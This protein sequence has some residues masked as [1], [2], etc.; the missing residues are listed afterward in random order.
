MYLQKVVWLFFLCCLSAENIF[1]GNPEEWNPEE[2]E[3]LS[4]QCAV[5]ENALKRIKSS[6]SEMQNVTQNLKNAYDN[7]K[8]KLEHLSNQ[9]EL[10]ADQCMLLLENSKP[11][12]KNSKPYF[13]DSDPPFFDLD[14]TLKGVTCLW[15]PMGELEE[16]LRILQNQE[17]SLTGEKILAFSPALQYEVENLSREEQAFAVTLER[18][19]KA[20]QSSISEKKRG[21]GIMIKGRYR[22]YKGNHYEVVDV[23]R[24]SETLEKLVLYRPLYGDGGL[25]VGPFDMFFETIEIEGQPQKRFTYVGE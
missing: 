1:A 17:A 5:R 22:H 8:E 24:H 18:E 21:C 16:L 14:N 15:K 19:L 23:V 25:W 12:F 6:V 2:W 9:I 20:F 10:I 3:K 7:S 13:K 11:Y 4:E